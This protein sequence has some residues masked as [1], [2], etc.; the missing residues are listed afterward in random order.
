MIEQVF[1]DFLKEYSVLSLPLNLLRPNIMK[2]ASFHSFIG[3]QSAIDK[4]QSMRK[5]K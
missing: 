5:I 3:N 1:N 4:T 2:N